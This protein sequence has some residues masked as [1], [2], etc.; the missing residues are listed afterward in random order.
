M[1]DLE[2]AD[3]TGGGGGRVLFVAA[4]GA[5]VG[6]GLARAGT[7][8]L[9]RAAG[10]GTGTSGAAFGAGLGTAGAGRDAREAGGGGC[11]RA[12]GAGG[13]I[14]LGLTH[15]EAP[16]FLFQKYVLPSDTCSDQSSADSAD[17]TVTTT[18]GA[19]VVAA[20]TA[21]SAAGRVH[22]LSPVTEFHQYFL[23][24]EYCSDHA[25]AS[26]PPAAGTGAGE[27]DALTGDAF[28][29]KDENSMAAGL[30][31][32]AVAVAEGDELDGYAELYRSLL[33]AP[34]EVSAGAKHAR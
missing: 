27:R 14:T 1:G 15:D 22:E 34:L 5:G 6:A 11:L 4:A 19:A 29:L 25:L 17:S 28:G 10:A 3:G 33:F 7:G 2:R 18:A 31:A 20:A 16:V 8:G 32:V 30:D 23:P 24:S 12:T 21:P 9:D 13:A 26:L